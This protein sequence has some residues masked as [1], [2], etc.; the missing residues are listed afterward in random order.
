MDSQH[1]RENYLMI[2]HMKSYMLN[3]NINEFYHYTICMFDGEYSNRMATI[4]IS[5]PIDIPPSN[6]Q[7]ILIQK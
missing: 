2:E 3:E 1:S 4:Q 7:T 6:N 5:L